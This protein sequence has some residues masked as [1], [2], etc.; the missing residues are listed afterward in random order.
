MLNQK[1]NQESTNCVG[2]EEVPKNN[3]SLQNSNYLPSD[4]L[5]IDPIENARKRRAMLDG[6]D[7]ED[8]SIDEHGW[9]IT[10]EMM[11]AMDNSSWLRKELSDGGLRQMIAEIDNADWESKNEPN[12][13]QRRRINQAEIFS[14]RE[15]ALERTKYTNEKFAKFVDKLMLTAG[16]LVEKEPDPEINAKNFAA[17][18]SGD[19]DPNNLALVSVPSRRKPKLETDN[20]S[21]S[22]SSSN[23]SDND[24]SSDEGSDGE[25]ASGKE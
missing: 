4:A 19:I 9:R 8:D 23:D 24:E 11:E 14:P 13:N 1:D 18:I 17:L 16:V 7:S 15:T 12:R 21:S 25:S 3:A 20:S 6:S 10:K 22:S 2:R 5:N